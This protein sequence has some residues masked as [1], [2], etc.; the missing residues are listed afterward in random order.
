[1]C[2]DGERFAHALEC[3]LAKTDGHLDRM[4][5]YDKS[6]QRVKSRN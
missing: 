2:H 6:V 4:H 5:G 3:V 1:M